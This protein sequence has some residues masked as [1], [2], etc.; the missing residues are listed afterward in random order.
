[1][2][3]NPKEVLVLQPLNASAL[4]IGSKTHCRFHMCFD[5]NSCILSLREDVLGVHVRDTYDFYDPSN[6]VSLSLNIS[7]AYT[8]L[9]DAVKKSRFYVSNPASACVFIPPVDTLAQ[10]NL[11]LN[12][13]STVLNTL[14]GYIHGGWGGCVC[15]LYVNFSNKNNQT[16]VGVGGRMTFLVLFLLSFF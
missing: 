4:D 11:D 15:V 10:Q 14:P 16:S 13:T 7:K 3:R 1:M 5:I 2:S 8:E 9:L 6:S 12:L